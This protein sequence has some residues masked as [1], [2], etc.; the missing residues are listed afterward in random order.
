[1]SPTEIQPVLKVVAESAARFCDTRDAAIFLVQDGMLVPKAHYG[2]IYFDY[3]SKPLTPDLV[4]AR[5]VIDREP[6]HLHDVMSAGA[7]FA[8]SKAVAELAGHRT[9]LA[10]PLISESEAIGALLIR[11]DEV[12]PF[13]KKQIELLKTFADQAAIAIQNVKLFEQLKSRTAE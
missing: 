2:P 1:S 5:A 11:R 13:S 7:E 3:T 9:L 12:R 6:V 8:A 10:T 4:S